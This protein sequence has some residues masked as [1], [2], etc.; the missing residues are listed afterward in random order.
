MKDVTGWRGP[1][2]VM[3]SAVHG[4]IP[5]QI[6]DKIV[7]VPM[8]LVRDF[9]EEIFFGGPQG[10]ALLRLMRQI[11]ALPESSVQILETLG[12]L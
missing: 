1:R 3:G 10:S 6:G 8:E 11:D 4:N 9:K 12:M 2:I 5:I 7:P